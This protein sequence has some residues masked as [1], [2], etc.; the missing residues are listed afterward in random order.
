M[1]KKSGIRKGCRDVFRAFLVKNAHYDGNLE[2][3][4][5]QPETKLP[6][7]LISFSK[8]MHSTDYDQWVHFYEDDVSFERVWNRPRIYLPKLKKF[9]GVIS[10]DFSLYRDMEINFQGIVLVNDR[11]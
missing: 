1:A 9:R 8:A 2:I 5:L 11:G 4:V 7:G 3:P 10:P 6:N